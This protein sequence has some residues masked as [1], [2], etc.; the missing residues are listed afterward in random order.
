MTAW[1]KQIKT[2]K[3]SKGLICTYKNKTKTKT[4][5]N[6]NNKKTNSFYVLQPAF[7]SILSFMVIALYKSDSFLYML[8]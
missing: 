6:K 2:C 1:A 4:N 8:L 5:K 3:K 7:T